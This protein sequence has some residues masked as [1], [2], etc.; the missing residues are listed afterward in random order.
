MKTHPIRFACALLLTSILPAPATVLY[1]DLNSTNPVAPYASWNTAAAV[2]QDAIDAAAPGDQILVTNGLYQTGGRAVYGALTNRVVLD[3]A[4]AV[5][6][7]NGPAVTIIAGNPVIGDTAVRCA[8]LTNGAS[9]T[10]FTLT[11]GATR[12]D[13]GDLWLEQNGG[14]AWCESASAMLTNCVLASNQANHEGGGINGGTLEGCTLYSNSV[15]DADL[16]ATG[17]GGAVNSVLHHCTLWGNLAFKAGGA[18]SGSTLN[19]CVVA[20]NAAGQ[21]GGGVSG[22]TL[23]NCLLT[24]NSCSLGGGGGAND[25]TLLN[26]TLV[27]NSAS[28]AGGASGGTLSNCI[29]Y[30]NSGSYGVST[31]NSYACGLVNCCTAPEA[32]SSTFTNT[33]G[34]VDLDHGDYHLQAG[35]LCINAGDNGAAAGTLDLDGNP[36]VVGPYIDV[37]AYEYQAAA[38]VPLNVSFTATYTNVATGYAVAFTGAI[39]GHEAESFWDFGDGTRVTN[40]LSLSHLWTGPGNYT[41]RFTAWN[42][43]HL[44]GLSASI[45]VLVASNPTYYVALGNPHAVAPY[46][47]WATAAANIQDAVDLA[48]VAGTVWVSNEVY[49]TGGQKLPNEPNTTRVV[50]GK[51]LLLQSVNGPAVTLIKGYRGPNTTNDPSSIRCLSLSSGATLSGFTLTNGCCMSFGGGVRANPGAIVTNCIFS[52][53]A[54]RGTGGGGNA[55]NYYN[56]LFS[57]NSSALVGGGAVPG[58]MNNCVV[59]G[60]F[61]AGNGGGVYNGFLT[62]CTVVGNYSGG[63]GGGAYNTMVQNCIVYSNTIGTVV[64]AGTNTYNGRLNNCCTTPLPT[65]G[66]GNFTNPPAFVNLAGGDFH[67]LASSPCIN[68]GDN[69]S[70]NGSLDWDGNPR[71]ALGKVDLGPYEFQKAI[72][73]VGPHLAGGPVPP[74]TSWATSALNIQDAVDAAAAGDFVVVTNGTDQVGGRAVYGAELNRVVLT[75]GVTLLSVNGA[76]ATTIT[77]GSSTRCVYVGSNSVISGFTLSNGQAYGSDPVREASGGG[78]WCETGGLVGDCFITGNRTFSNGDRKSVV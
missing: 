21:Y 56:C 16:S 31:S 27:K 11:Q 26:C 70:V 50:V 39:A 42:S 33:P 74:Y 69:A 68:A 67:L 8:Y 9:L 15:Y 54:A 1:V 35:S 12:S 3:K 17:G 55:G 18:A 60:N 6:S 48:S 37:G 28:Y 24:T 20:G 57:G 10:G 23:A 14:G 64:S 22:S 61:A 4:V 63:A 45:T 41:V 47:S 46:S 34:F 2:L 36:R 73:Y 49:E 76:K 71:I 72:H 75:N 52:G 78:A 13:Q 19:Y 51:P 40:Q 58:L 62:N 32:G 77:G 30:Y 44:D 59:V 29:V 7:V 38:P 53:N 65:F 5:Q 43:D 25:S 66:T